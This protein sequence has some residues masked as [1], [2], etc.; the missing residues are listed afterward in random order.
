MPIHACNGEV[1][2]EGAG[3]I[4]L[5]APR[6]T[7]RLTSLVWG[8]LWSWV[9]RF[10]VSASHLPIIPNFPRH[11]VFVV[12]RGRGSCRWLQLESHA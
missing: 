8:R 12:V 3:P 1:A 5:H 2:V 10:P 9:A 7:C 6:R 11:M 4:T